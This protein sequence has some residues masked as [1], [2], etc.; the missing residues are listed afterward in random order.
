[1]ATNKTLL[2]T[3]TA[4]VAALFLSACESGSGFYR[5]AGSDVDEGGF[6]NPTMTNMLVQTG[7][8][9]A[10]HTLQ[11]RFAKEVV[12]TITFEFNSAVLTDSAQATLRQQA[13]WIRQF[14]E[15]RFKVFGHTDLVGSDAYNKSLGMRRARAAVNYL[16]A[17]GIGSARLE[18]VVSFGKTQPVVATPGPEEQNRRTVTEVAGF[19]RGHPTVMNGRYAEIIWRSFVNK[20]GDTSLA[21]RPHPVNSTVATQVNPAGE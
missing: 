16:S 15:V 21:E 4:L 8:I 2:L 3:S 12:S 5:E 11:N 17:Q 14:P 20:G 18:A 1:M 6:G 13:A 9:E 10:T 19:V 7:R